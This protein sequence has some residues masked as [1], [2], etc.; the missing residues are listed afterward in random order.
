MDKGGTTRTPTFWIV[1]VGIVHSLFGWLQAVYG[2]V[3]PKNRWDGLYLVY[4]VG[5]YLS[6]TLFN[7]ECLWTLLTKQSEN[8]VYQ[9]GTNSLHL[10][11]FKEV[12]LYFGIEWFFDILD[13]FQVLN[14]LGFV[15]LYL[16]MQRNRFPLW[17]TLG[18]IV[19]IILYT[20]SLRLFHP[21][22]HEKDVF[23]FI[24]NVFKVYFSLVLI[25]LVWTFLKRII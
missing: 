21:N 23:L 17:L 11:D 10:N 7:G 20:Q 3:I 22:L 19:A 9:A 8:P 1:M 14:V 15:S 24:Q 13:R 5:V 25:Y 6:W 12:G 18:T 4:I 16:V 2:M